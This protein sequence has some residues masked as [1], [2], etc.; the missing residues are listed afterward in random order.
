MMQALTLADT[1]RVA[2]GL[3]TGVLLGL[4]YFLALRRTV[5]RFVVRPSWP[6][7]I[8][9]TLVRVLGAATV[10][11]VTARLGALALLAALLGF[12]LARGLAL[13]NRRGAATPGA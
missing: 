9:S 10:L 3:A 4:L 8:V 12:L 1:L 13:R 7:L 11:A 5:S 6:G 2:A